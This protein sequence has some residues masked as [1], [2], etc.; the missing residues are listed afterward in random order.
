MSVADAKKESEGGK[1]EAQWLE[2]HPE[3]PSPGYS[4]V[5]RGSD[6][7]AKESAHAVTLA[8]A[9]DGAMVTLSGGN[10]TV[11]NG[12]LGRNLGT[13]GDAGLARFDINGTLSLSGANT[14]TGG[15]STR[16]N[17]SSTAFGYYEEGAGRPISFYDG[18]EMTTGVQL[19]QSPT[20]LMSSLLAAS[21]GG[22]NGLS[23][24]YDVPP[25][26]PERGGRID[27][28]GDAITLSGGTVLKGEVVS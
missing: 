12:A 7:P 28:D 9:N 16:L 4:F 18:T 27:M 6:A 3:A 23:Y 19:V 21:P 26:A 24:F 15:V 2:E 17:R 20:V 1:S 5:A 22:A 8:K 10:L 25:A 11:S 14:Y 13:A